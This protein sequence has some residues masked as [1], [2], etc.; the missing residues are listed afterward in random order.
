MTIRIK[1]KIKNTKK[2]VQRGGAGQNPLREKLE[3]GLNLKLP[4]PIQENI[5]KYKFP[6]YPFLITNR[7]LLLR[8]PEYKSTATVIFNIIDEM[9]KINIEEAGQAKEEQRLKGLNK[10]L[11]DCIMRLLMKTICSTSKIND[12]YCKK[13]D[14]I[15]QLELDNLR[16][17]LEAPISWIDGFI[18]CHNQ[19]MAE[20]ATINS[21][22]V[23]K[24]Q[25]RSGKS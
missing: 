22:I 2:H 1:K 24:L 13:I 8:E 23:Q 15:N 17:I 10:L 14:T 12:S 16:V 7:E 3:D 9:Q 25:F 6:T 11:A 4:T 21:I 18:K 20:I 5:Y 19:C